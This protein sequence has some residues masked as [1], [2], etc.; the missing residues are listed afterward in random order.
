MLVTP[1]H[2]FPTGVVLS[3]D[4]R[5]ALLDWARSA[6]SLIVEDDYDAEFRHDGPPLGA[7]QRLA[8][9][10]VAYVGTAS[11]I[12]APALR[13]GW[14]ALPASMVAEA[15]DA[16]WCRDSGSPVLDQVALAHVLTRGDFDRSLRRALR[17]YRHR[18]DR[19]VAELAR[20]LPE[21]R[22]SGAAA[23]LHVVAIFDDLDETALV[24]FAEQRRVSLRG[25]RS[26]AVEP[27]AHATSDAAIALGYG[28][29]PEPSITD[30]VQALTEAARAVRS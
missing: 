10:Q 2:Q 24:E 11:K 5:R 26:Y 16:K 6:G 25:L 23:G 1:A 20:Q 13:L 21:A 4:R 22:I 27:T 18:R 19:L 14:L 9:E 28:R 12:L 15:A 3:P 8:P 29:L 17:S 30:A 7:L